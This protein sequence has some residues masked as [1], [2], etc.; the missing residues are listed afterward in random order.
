M[1]FSNVLDLTSL[2]TGNSQLIVRWRV[3]RFLS[4][5]A[6]EFLNQYCYTAFVLRFIG[7]GHDIIVRRNS[8]MRYGIMVAPGTANCIYHQF[9]KGLFPDGIIFF[10]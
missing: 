1:S 5:T 6:R 9:Q 8:T 7:R 4:A 3:E 10:G 2:N